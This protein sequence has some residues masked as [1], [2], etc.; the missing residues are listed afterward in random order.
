MRCE[1][2]RGMRRAPYARLLAAQRA[3]HDARV[4]LPRPRESGSC[5]GRGIC[6]VHSAAQLDG[7]G[8]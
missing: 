7:L 1:L 3:Q 8:L 2:P 6:S 4:V 5:Q